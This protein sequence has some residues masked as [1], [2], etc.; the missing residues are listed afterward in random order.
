MP[1]PDC[2]GDGKLPVGGPKLEWRL[3]QIEAAAARGAG[4]TSE[5]DLRWLVHELRR[6]RDTLLYVLTRCQDA[7][8]GDEMANDIKYRINETLGLYDVPRPP[9]AS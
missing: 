4:A 7:D 8:E 6:S 5:S 1:C 3:R 2:F 9:N